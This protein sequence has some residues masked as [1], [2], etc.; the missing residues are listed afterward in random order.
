MLAPYLD[1]PTNFFVV[2]SDFCHWGSRFDFNPMQPD[3]PIHQTI[4][5]L[6]HE[7]MRLIEALDTSSFAAYLQR[8]QN[9]ICGRHP[10]A[11]Y[12][13]ALRGS[14]K[15]WDLQFVKYDQSSKV[16]RPNDSSVSY[17]SAIVTE[18]N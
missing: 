2:S 10:I 9:T 14:K 8:T 12:I 11:V 1:D 17:A 5:N 4:S 18:K 3:E 15:E 16:I 7:A 6:D 13:H